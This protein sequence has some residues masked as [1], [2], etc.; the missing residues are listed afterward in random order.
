MKCN[1][2][3]AVINTI[4]QSMFTVYDQQQVQ[5]IL[6]NWCIRSVFKMSCLFLRPRLWQFEI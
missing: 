3:V 6:N 5:R 4:H 2:T 1:I